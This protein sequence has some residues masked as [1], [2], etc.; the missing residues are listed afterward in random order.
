METNDAETTTKTVEGQREEFISA[1]ENLDDPSTLLHFIE[2]HNTSD[3]FDLAEFLQ[4][5]RGLHLA[6]LWR[7]LYSTTKAIVE[8]SLHRMDLDDNVEDEVDAR[9]Q[10]LQAVATIA[11]NFLTDKKRPVPDAMQ[12]T[13]QLMHD[14]ML[15]LSSDRG[16]ALQND[17]ARTCEDMWSDE[18]Q[19]REGLIT[20]TM[21]YLVAR[22]LDEDGKVGDLKRVYAMRASLLLLEFQD[23]SIA[24]MK[25]LLLRCFVHPLF[26]K[27]AEGRKFCVYLFGLHPSFISDIHATVKQQ[28]PYASKHTCELYGEIYFKA[29]RTA[30]GPYLTRIENGCIQTLMAAAVHASTVSLFNSLRRVL[31][32]FHSQKKARGVDEMLLRLYAPIIWRA[33]SAANPHVRRSAATLLIDTFPLHDPDSSLEAM[34]EILQ[35]Q[36]DC[37]RELL[38]DPTV[39]VRCVG[40]S[41]ICRILCV[42]WEV[43]PPATTRVFLNLLVQQSS[44]D[45]NAAALRVAV[46][47]GL[48]YLLDNQLSH[49]A[50]RDCLPHLA[51]LIHDRS[52]KVRSAFVRLLMQVKHVRAIRFYH[53]VAIPE[54]LSRLA[55]ECTDGNVTQIACDLVDLLINSYMPYEKDGTTQ[56]RRCLSLCKKN[57]RAAVV[58]YR[59]VY[60]WVP[61]PASVSLGCH[62]LD[63]AEDVLS[64]GV[65]AANESH[66]LVQEEE[67][68]PDNVPK[69]KKHKKGTAKDTA[70]G[71]R[72]AVQVRLSEVELKMLETC[73]EVSL[74]LLSHQ[75][76]VDKAAPEE[77]QLEAETAVKLVTKSVTQTK[78]MQLLS[79]PGLR[80]NTRAWASLVRIAALLPAASV[81]KLVTD[82]AA[83]LTELP[84]LAQ[85]SEFEPLLRCMVA[86][87]RTDQIFALLKSALLTNQ[88]TPVPK[89]AKRQR[90]DDDDDDDDGEASANSGSPMLGLRIIDFMLATPSLSEPLLAAESQPLLLELQAAIFTKIGDFIE[91][92]RGNT[93]CTGGWD[94][95]AT[96]NALLIHCKL[97]V[98]SLADAMVGPRDSQRSDRLTK[99]GEALSEFFVW[100]TESIGSYLSANDNEDSDPPPKFVPQACQ[101]VLAIA[102]ET[103]ALG[104]AAHLDPGCSMHLWQCQHEFALAA[105]RTSHGVT[106]GSIAATSKLIAQA[107]DGWTRSVSGAGSLEVPCIPRKKL[108]QLMQ[109]LGTHADAETVWPLRAVF[110]RLLNIYKKLPLTTYAEFIADG[111]CAAATVAISLPEA[112]APIAET[113]GLSEGDTPAAMTA[114]VTQL[115]DGKS[116]GRGAFGRLG[117]QDVQAVMASLERQ[118]IKNSNACTVRNDDGSA[119]T[120]SDSIQAMATM[121]DLYRVVQLLVAVTSGPDGLRICSDAKDTAAQRVELAIASCAGS[122]AVRSGLQGINELMKAVCV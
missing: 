97:L 117:A 73:L 22:A 115:R 60:Q 107:H 12:K 42:Y 53:V 64:S 31:G 95:E 82:C 4:S 76:S 47:E 23:P 3:G 105:L 94:D 1:A 96:L 106:A 41:G 110:S 77:E 27:T 66:G 72:N 102:A 121:G 122:S 21:P 9:L 86:W 52:P 10:V 120:L 98:R 43:I 38:T 35:K 36:F 91:V 92:L 84:P 119:G 108:Y 5:V 88:S 81:S 49:L 39:A 100:A 56:L 89:E 46:C 58:F 112:N 67:N 74:E 50:L 24:S 99:A 118:L 109:G 70:K 2:L 37:L 57:A 63:Y 90:V 54:L 32:A 62:L 26:L 59:S 79:A 78:L 7:G 61:A 114:L 33:L 69:S 51:F 40:V 18:R 55:H 17:I 15:E 83:Q 44:H 116:R 25:D 34:D 101:L 48:G 103:H 11:M 104:A 80:G 20:Q 30:S 28:L 71:K 29:W 16:W 65:D 45:A 113:T 85:P 8:N 87:G 14:V 93:G 111:L 75:N 6:R 19:G 13:I 68:A